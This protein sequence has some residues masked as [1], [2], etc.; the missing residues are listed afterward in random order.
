MGVSSILVYPTE[1]W[2][3]QSHRNTSMGV[4]RDAPGLDVW[5]LSPARQ[6]WSRSASQGHSMERGEWSWGIPRCW[7]GSE[8]EA[9]S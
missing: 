2:A 1:P 3:Q 4:P 9:G 5:I 7:V 8:V 6:G